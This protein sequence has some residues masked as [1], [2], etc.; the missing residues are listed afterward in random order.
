MCGGVFGHVGCLNQNLD[1]HTGRGIIHR[2]RGVFCDIG[3]I[4]ALAHLQQSDE[5]I[6]MPARD[7]TAEKH[8]LHNRHRIR[9]AL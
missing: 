5:T 3:C 7:R 9:S 4:A 8:R 1:H 6:Q 2:M